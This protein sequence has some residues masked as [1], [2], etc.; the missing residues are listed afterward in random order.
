MFLHGDKMLTREECNQ[1][2]KSVKKFTKAKLFY[3]G[4]KGETKSV[5]MPNQ[6][7]SLQK[8]LTL[9]KGTLLY[10]K[11]NC[12]I[13]KNGYSLNVN[14]VKFNILKYKKGHFIYKH[15]HDRGGNI[16]LTF[17][18][19]LNDSSDYQGGDFVYWIDGKEYRMDREIG[20]GLIIGPEVEHEVEIVTQGER[21]SFI[22]FLTY[23]ELK[24]LS[25]PSI[26]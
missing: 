10:N 19:Q 1:L 4:N 21:H 20:Y 12:L 6:R 14:S 24:S 23:P 2:V 18:I 26:I 7:N 3:K 13:E 5:F 11:I 9:H 15:K 22:L 25:K 8:Q 17:V 16:F